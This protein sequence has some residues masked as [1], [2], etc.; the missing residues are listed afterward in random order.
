MSLTVPGSENANGL[1]TLYPWAEAI[2]TFVWVVD[3]RMSDSTKYRF[4]LFDDLKYLVVER[5]QRGVI[6]CRTRCLNPRLPNRNLRIIGVS[7]LILNRSAIEPWISMSVIGGQTAGDYASCNAHDDDFLRVSPCA[8]SRIVLS[9]SCRGCCC[10][11]RCG[12]RHRQ[13]I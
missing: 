8:A 10:H 12:T 4:D 7:V 5:K 3:A 9:K 2:L 13:S 6:R 1:V 11:V